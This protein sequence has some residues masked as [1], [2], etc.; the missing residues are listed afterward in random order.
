VPSRRR[1]T[2]PAV[3]RVTQ[4]TVVLAL[5][6]T[7][8]GY[9]ALRHSVPVLEPSSCTAVPAGTSAQPVSLNVGQAGVAATIAAV[10][11]RHKLPTRAVTIAYATAL[12]E[13]KLQDLSYGDLDSVGVFQQRPSEGWGSRQHL[14][15]PVYAS[16]RFFAALTAVPRYQ[17]LHIYQAAQAVQRSADGSAYDQYA[18]QGAAMAGGFS[19]HLPHDVWCWYPGGIH[20]H[21]KLTAAGTQLRRTFGPLSIGHAG[22]P[23][24][25]VRVPGTDTGWAVAAWLVSHASRF[26]IR[27]VTYQGYEW[28]AARGRKGWTSQPKARHGP[29]PRLGIAFG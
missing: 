21:A 6:L 18:P 7:V 13:S 4:A 24:A 16:T 1:Q 5:L 10:A 3:R 15:D 17:H 19:G 25:L 11:Q 20:G 23:V 8:G 27:H 28:T 22:D 14:L 9:V 2:R 29:A 12:Q 26:G